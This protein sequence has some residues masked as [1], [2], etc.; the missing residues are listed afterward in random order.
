[1]TAV[2]R[3]VTMRSP[4]PNIDKIELSLFFTR[5]G[6]AY[7]FLMWSF[8]KLVNPEHA[9]KVFGHFYKTDIST[10]TAQLIGVLQVL[11]TL[12]FLFGLWKSITYLA[13]FVL[14]TISVFSSY[15]QILH[16]FAEGNQLFVAGLSVWFAL[17]GLYIA[18]KK[19]TLWTIKSD[20]NLGKNVEE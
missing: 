11:L 18:R 15:D 1:V 4:L 7:L 14:H 20:K 17:L 12:A 9:I 5:L 3:G 2:E 19:D 13:V 16:P 10:D 6:T 8:D